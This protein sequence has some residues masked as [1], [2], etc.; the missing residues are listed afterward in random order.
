[1]QKDS[2]K[3]KSMIFNKIL[4][5]QIQQKSKNEG[6]KIRKSLQLLN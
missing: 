5:N 4:I 2:T 6:E 3:S 1:M